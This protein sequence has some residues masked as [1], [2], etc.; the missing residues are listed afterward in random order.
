M[1]RIT[2]CVLALQEYNLTWEFIPERK[3]V[4]ADTL[5][6]INLENLMFEGDKE[7]IIKVCHIIKARRDLEN[8]VNKI[9]GRQ[10]TDEKLTNHKTYG[11]G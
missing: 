3:N 1:K 9:K 8:I 6:R 2:R 10:Q 11:L 4:T 7:E 5:S